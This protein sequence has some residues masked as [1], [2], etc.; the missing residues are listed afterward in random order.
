MSG[1]Y[2]GFVDVGFL[3]A[4][5]AR[6]TGRRSDEVGV[7]AAQVVERKFFDAIARTP[8]LQLRLGHIAEHPPRLKRPMQQAL[9]HTAD[10]LGVDRSALMNEFDKH[11]T[12][13]PD[14]QQKGVDT[15]IALD[16]VRFAGR[17]GFDTAILVS[18]DRDLAEAVRAAQDFGV[19]V[20][21]AVPTGQ[22]GL[23][24]ELA[25]LADEI[26]PI[27]ATHLTTMLPDR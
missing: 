25:Q 24:T 4:Q 26:L 2:A 10:G 17:S 23:A 20:F 6:A 18:G 21:V 3:K 22:V 27:G 8:G 9:R 16:M 12:F 19:K 11:W 1:S 7:D 14:R 5:G 15:L 13:H